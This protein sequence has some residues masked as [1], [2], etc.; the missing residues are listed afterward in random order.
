MSRTMCSKC[1]KKCFLVA[2]PFEFLLHS[3][4]FCCHAPVCPDMNPCEDEHIF[5]WTSGNTGK[6][7]EYLCC[8][9]GQVKY[10]D[11]KESD[12]YDM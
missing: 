8:Q 5:S 9:C 10:S 1:G 11:L 2:V 4:S 3:V 7:P 6:P 12:I